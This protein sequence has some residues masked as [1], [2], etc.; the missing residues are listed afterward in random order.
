MSNV[1]TMNIKINKEEFVKNL[2]DS[3]KTRSSQVLEANGLTDDPNS[4][5]FSQYQWITG[6]YEDVYEIIKAS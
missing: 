3:L 1:S 6:I 5:S 2:I 4:P